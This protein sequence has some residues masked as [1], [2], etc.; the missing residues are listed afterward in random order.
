[1]STFSLIKHQRVR[2][3]NW[4]IVLEV[5]GV[6]GAF[7]SIASLYCQF[8]PPLDPKGW[9]RRLVR[10]VQ[11]WV[12]QRRRHLPD[13]SARRGPY[14]PGPRVVRAVGHA[15]GTSMV[16]GVARTS[17]GGEPIDITVVSPS[18]GFRL[19]G[20]PPTVSVSASVH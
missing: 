3:Y 5:I 12:A 10:A 6:L 16:L 7:A 20:Y 4:Q 17:G 19:T 18:G 13:F 1:M 8:G 11:Q 2:A 14:L 9:W 15:A